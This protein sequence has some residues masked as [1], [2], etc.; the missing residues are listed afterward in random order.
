MPKPTQK[1]FSVQCFRWN[2][3]IGGGG[4]GRWR[5]RWLSRG[6][7]GTRYM[8]GVSPSMYILGNSQRYYFQ[9]LWKPYQYNVS[10]G[11]R[12]LVGAVGDE[13]KAAC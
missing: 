13:D 10:G 6:R 11:A 2:Q 5:F 1:L 7:L 8:Q 9:P 4:G 3:G 12:V